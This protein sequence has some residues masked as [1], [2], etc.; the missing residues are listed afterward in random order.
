LHPIDP[1]R[2][3]NDLTQDFVDIIADMMHKDPK[4]RVATASEVV[5]R[6]A[7]WVENMVPAGQSVP[8]TPPPV[9]GGS[10]R[11]S[12]T[13]SRELLGDSFSDSSEHA[14]Q[15]THPISAAS[16]ETAET[17]TGIEEVDAER[18]ESKKSRPRLWTRISEWQLPESIAGFHPLVFA[19]LAAG[20]LVAMA[21]LGSIVI[22]SLM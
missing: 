5:A 12:D 2:L 13:D 22:S 10:G 6:L 20:A 16:E 19:V 17:I 9:G 21:V 18:L 3:N 1:R 14:S 4:K 15:P 8:V 11:F 7:P